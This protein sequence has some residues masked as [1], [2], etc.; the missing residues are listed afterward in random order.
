MTRS[1]RRQSRLRG[2][3][4]HF[5]SVAGTVP[6]STTDLHFGT[7]R[8]A[9]RGPPDDRF[10]PVHRTQQVL[11]LFLDAVMIRITFEAASC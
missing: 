11:T 9:L 6:A 4:L 5:Y 8:A 3:N 2:C 7:S 10:E 1:L